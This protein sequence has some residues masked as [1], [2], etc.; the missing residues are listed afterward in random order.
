MRRF[1]FLLCSAA[2]FCAYLPVAFAQMGTDLFRRPAIAKVFNPV[3]GKGAEY[4]NSQKGDK[5]T[6]TQMGV[7]GRESVEG[8]DGYWIQFIMNTE[9]GVMIAKVLFTKDDF[10]FHRSI[11]QMPG[12]P[13]M[14]L[15]YNG[16]MRDTKMRER[17]NEWHS[18]GTE[19]IT[20]P[21]G[22]FSCEHWRN[23]KDNSD[24][25]TS[26]KVAPYGMVKEQRSGSGMV[27]TKI[28]SDFPDRITGP[29]KKFD[30]QE[31]MQQMKER[32]QD[33]G[34]RNP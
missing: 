6:I 9:K 30:M 16:A 12:Q 34:Q 4:E 2:L 8:K 23:D 13:A 20:V 32:Q 11:M 24:I 3:I 33:R 29:V 18:V 22:T 25:W 10:E 7:V 15:P 1:A 17:L 26:D 19:T 28:L 21:A 31:M 5:T 27:L 14:E